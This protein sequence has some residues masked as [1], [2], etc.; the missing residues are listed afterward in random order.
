MTDQ[1]FTVP[2]MAKAFLTTSPYRAK[3]WGTLPHSWPAHHGG[4]VRN[5]GALPHKYQRMIGDVDGDGS[6]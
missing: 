2:G 5:Y 1:I 4:L 6:D 3:A